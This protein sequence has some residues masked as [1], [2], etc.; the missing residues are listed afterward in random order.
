MTDIAENLRNILDER[1]TYASRRIKYLEAE[2]KKMTIDSYANPMKM[3]SIQ[4]EID[5]ER[6]LQHFA[7]SLLRSLN[8]NEEKKK[9]DR[10]NKTD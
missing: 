6:E 4:M 7:H 2:K 5:S 10:K 9:N 8:V 3:V 1:I